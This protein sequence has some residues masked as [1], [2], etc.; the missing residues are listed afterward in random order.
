[1]SARYDVIERLRK[2]DADVLAKC[3]RET[4]WSIVRSNFDAS[5]PRR[6]IGG[7]AVSSRNRNEKGDAIIAAGVTGLLPEL[8]L[9]NH[10][11]MMPLGKVFSMD[12]WEGTLLFKAELCNSGRVSWIEQ[13]WGH[14]V[15]GRVSAAS[16]SVTRFG[17]EIADRVFRDSTL[18]EMSVVEGGAD[19]GA[20]IQ[21]VWEVSP[22]VHVDPAKPTSKLIWSAL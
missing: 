16:I 20:R 14:I 3:S 4:A 7:V 5:K 18:E 10:D 15:E 1:M 13:V 21:R 2:R 17:G 8:L 12:S 6:F 19:P 22:V 9:W 11:F